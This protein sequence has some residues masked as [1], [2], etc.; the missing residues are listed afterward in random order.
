M[1]VSRPGRLVEQDDLIAAVRPDT[2]LGPDDGMRDRYP[3]C[4]SGQG[5]SELG[6]QTPWN[7]AFL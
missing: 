4:E 6:R 1:R 2:V 3:L 5:L 7:P